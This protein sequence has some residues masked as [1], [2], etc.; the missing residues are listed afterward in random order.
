MI[1]SSYSSNLLSNGCPHPRRALIQRQLSMSRGNRA[2]LLI[3]HVDEATERLITRQVELVR[4]ASNKEKDTGTIAV[5]TAEIEACTTSMIRAVEDLLVV[6]RGLKEAWVLGHVR[7][8]NEPE[9][10]VQEVDQVKAAEKIVSVLK[11]NI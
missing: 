5:E 7:E 2:Q 10:E 3:D 8:Q 9:A 1:I 11:E 4:L 6:T